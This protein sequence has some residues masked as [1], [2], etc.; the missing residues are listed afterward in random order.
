MKRLAVVTFIFSAICVIV[1]SAQSH[2]VEWGHP[3]AFDRLLTRDIVNRKYKF[4]RIIHEDYQFPAIGKTNYLNI[5]GIR[6]T[7]QYMD[8]TGGYASLVQ[9]GL[10][11]RNVTIHLK[12]Q[13]NHGFNFIIE[14][15]GR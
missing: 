2:N 8:G 10:G 9:G 15:F 6:V 7:D 11:H 13:R 12:S 3:S 5:T 1:I 14:I 4:W